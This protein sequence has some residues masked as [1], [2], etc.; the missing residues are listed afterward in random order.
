MAARVRGAERVTKCPG[1]MAAPSYASVPHLQPY[2]Y[3]G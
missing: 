1:S 2:G 3:R